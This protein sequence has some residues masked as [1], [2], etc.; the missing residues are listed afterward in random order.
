MNFGNLPA[1]HILLTATPFAQVRIRVLH[2]SDSYYSRK[3]IAI[4][5]TTTTILMSPISILES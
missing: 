1:T 4:S 2:S 3:K 5:V